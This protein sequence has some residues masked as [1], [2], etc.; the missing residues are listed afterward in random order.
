VLEL[1]VE[2]V[3]KRIG[4]FTLRAD[5]RVAPGERAAVA[6]PSGS[7]KTTLL[8]LLAGLDPV[9]SGRIRLG[10]E[11]ITRL[12]PERRG[13]GMVFQEQTLFPSM[14][15][16]EN[17]AFGLRMAGVGRAAREAETRPWLER[18]GLGARAGE[19]VTVLSGGE[20]QRVAFV[21][22]LVWKPKLL[23]LDEPFSALDA[24]LRERLQGELVELHRLWPVP[25]LLV[26]H[27]AADAAVATSR[28]SCE[29]GEGGAVRVFSRPGSAP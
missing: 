17:A 19:S 27:D 14:T 20:R 12:P 3:V 9:D 13:I 18:V 29:I 7:G 25:L 23:L 2:N 1:K 6:G 11:D 5:F 8:R 21:R 15:V 22:A 4:G 28:I 10:D 16:L 24:A 26:S